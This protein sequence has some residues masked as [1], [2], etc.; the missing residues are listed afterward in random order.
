MA[1]L[2]DSWGSQADV[3]ERQMEK[4]EGR[5]EVKKIKKEK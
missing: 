4:G 1:L 5:D 2:I 3:R